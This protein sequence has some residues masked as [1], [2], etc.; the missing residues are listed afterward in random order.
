LRPRVG[1]AITAEA[2]PAV[3]SANFTRIRLRVAVGNAGTVE[4]LVTT[5]T[6][7]ALVELSTAVGHAIA[8]DTL[9]GAPAHATAVRFQEAVCQAITAN[10]A[11]QATALAAFVHLQSWRLV[12][13]T[14]DTREPIATAHVA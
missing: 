2:A 3:A 13:G 5:G 6:D 14:V 11:V 12:S 7:A 9:V 10:T 8:T 1:L 4:T